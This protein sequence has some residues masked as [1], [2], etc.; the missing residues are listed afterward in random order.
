[1]NERVL[2]ALRK[3][4]WFKGFFLFLPYVFITAAIGCAVVLVFENVIAPSEYYR[5]LTGSAGGSAAVEDVTP[6]EGHIPPIAYESQWATLNVEGWEKKDIPVYFGDSKAV[7]RR[8]AGMWFNSRF[9]G[10]KGKTVISAHVTSHF[11]EIEDTTV[12]TLVTMDT[13]YG[14]YVYKVTDI[15]IFGYKDNAFIETK[16]EDDDIL[17]LYTCYPRENG[18][19]F[20]TERMALICKRISGEEWQTYG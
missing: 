2:A 1:M 8:G 12:G 11:Y 14:D 15:E 7:L 9:C 16:P 18:Y 13:I 19:Q 6:E 3:S 10:Q 17:L 4:P 5:V 20:K